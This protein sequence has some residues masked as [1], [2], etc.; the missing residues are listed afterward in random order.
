MTVLTTLRRSERLSWTQVKWQRSGGRGIL[1]SW[2]SA[3]V[4]IRGKGPL[5]SAHAEFTGSGLGLGTFFS[6]LRHFFAPSESAEALGPFPA[7]PSL[8]VGS[9]RCFPEINQG[10][11]LEIHPVVSR[12]QVGFLHAGEWFCHIEVLQLEH[13]I[14]CVRVPTSWDLPC[15]APGFLVRIF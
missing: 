1:G 11:F 5:S 9:E 14:N 6:C 3:L 8:G 4:W 12:R 2:V 7:L 13:K 10:I 15:W